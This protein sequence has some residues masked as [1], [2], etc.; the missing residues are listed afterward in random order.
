MRA[1]DPRSYDAPKRARPLAIE[2]DIGLIKA[3]AVQGQHCIYTGQIKKYARTR[4]L[5]DNYLVEALKGWYINHLDHYRAFTEADWHR[6]Y[7]PFIS[8]YC[9]TF[10]GDEW[11]LSQEYSLLR[12]IGE[13]G[14]PQQIVIHVAKP[15]TKRRQLLFNYELCTWPTPAFTASGVSVITRNGIPA[16]TLAESI[17]RVSPS[18]IRQ[19]KSAYTKALSLVDNV[20]TLIEPLRSNVRTT[21]AGRIA[22]ALRHVG[23][24]DDAKK[25]KAAIT[26]EELRFR[27]SNPFSSRPA[28]P[29]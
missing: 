26:G 1:M 8:F 6:M 25:L 24:K 18:R 10:F 11:H 16:M 2:K 22:S 28:F 5:Q 27:G 7:E 20:D 14:M 23:R 15:T 9:G 17:I 12:H 19:N 3:L 4:L 13:M 29:T 21:I